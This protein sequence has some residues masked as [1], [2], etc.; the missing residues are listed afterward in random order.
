MFLYRFY[1]LSPLITTKFWW[2][3]ALSFLDIKDWKNI[4]FS[5]I[6]SIIFYQSHNK[7]R[8]VHLT[9]V[10]FTF[11]SYIF[12]SNLP[13]LPE[14]VEKD[15]ITNSVLLHSLFKV[16]VR[17][18]K[19]NLHSLDTVSIKSTWKGKKEKRTISCTIQ[20]DTHIGEDFEFKIWKYIVNM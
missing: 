11:C 7:G 10:S 16:F 19:G 12:P 2:K 13:A 17:T 3:I 14:L 9:S 18:L 6:V 1:I 8:T 4:I 5:Q 15:V 20:F